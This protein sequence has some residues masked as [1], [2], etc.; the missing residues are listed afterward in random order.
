MDITRILIASTLFFLTMSA[1][2]STCTV[3]DVDSL[4][5]CINQGAAVDYYDIQSD[6]SCSGADCCASGDALISLNGRN[7]VT[8]Q[9]N[10]HVITRHSNQRVCPAITLHGAANIA[11]SSLQI[12]ED[13]SAPRCVGNENC[14]GTI[15][16]YEGSNFTLEDVGIWN[17]K[18]VGIS[19][20]GVNQFL[21]NNSTIVRAGVIGVYAG[22]GSTG[23]KVL[24]SVIARS[25]ANGIAFQNVLGPNSLSHNLIW[26]N[27]LDGN[28]ELGAYVTPLSSPRF[29]NG[30]QIY[31]PYAKSVDVGS[32]VIV[33]GRCTDCRGWGPGGNEAGGGISAIELG[34]EGWLD[35]VTISW[36]KIRNHFGVSFFVNSTKMSGTS[37]IWDNDSRGVKGLWFSRNTGN[38]GPS[39]GR[40]SYGDYSPSAYSSGYLSGAIQRVYSAGF[41]QEANWLGQHPGA[42]FE[43][44]FRLADWP[45][46]RGSKAPIYRCLTWPTTSND[47]VSLDSGCEGYHLHSILG[48]SYPANHPGAQPFYRCMIPTAP[49]DQFVSSDAGCE[50]QYSHG[51]LGYFIPQ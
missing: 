23:V 6:F 26:K 29:V 30:G 1:L 38:F 19:V 34:N 36:N 21:L 32:N 33:N 31:I 42:L 11:I 5:N 10:G 4:R 9:G 20:H 43:Q 48:Y 3:T 25:G 22:G 15:Y 51:F 41:H 24:R 44:A 50:G 16:A 7:G 45:L 37:A 47:F 8:I 18:S 12:D 27:V 2:A 14:P 17:S 28:H 13:E 49:Y 46:P 39:S 40:N 35:Y